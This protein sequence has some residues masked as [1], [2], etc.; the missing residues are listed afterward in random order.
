MVEAT[1]KKAVP[2]IVVNAAWCKKCGICIAYCPTKVFEPAKDGLP[3]V[4]RQDECTWC[5]LCE[6]RCP[7]FAI[8]LRGEKDGANKE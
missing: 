7:D 5:E 3:I 8:I 1:K 6:L 2:E 4:V